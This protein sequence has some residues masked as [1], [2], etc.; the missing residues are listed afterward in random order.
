MKHSKLLII[1]ISLC[2]FM[3]LFA[4]P[5]ATQQMQGITV[6]GVGGVVSCSSFCDEY[7]DINFTPAQA[8]NGNPDRPWMAESDFN[9]QTGEWIQFTFTRPVGLVALRISPGF[10]HTEKRFYDYP[11][12]KKFHVTINKAAEGAGSET[13]HY[14]RRFDGAPYKDLILLYSTQPLVK[15]IRLHI[16]DVFP[17]KLK[18]YALIGNIEPIFMM[19]GQLQCSSTAVSDVLAFLH[20]SGNPESSF[21]FVPSGRPITIHKI[22]RNA[23]PLDPRGTIDKSDQFT[24]EQ[25][26]QQWDV[27]ADLSRRIFSDYQFKTY[28]A[29][30]YF[31][32]LEGGKKVFFDMFGPEHSDEMN[33]FQMAL[34][35]QQA[36]EE[37]KTVDPET[38]EEKVTTVTIM[39]SVVDKIMM[40]S[41]IYTP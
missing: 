36:T 16:D 12:L 21:A 1:C 13:R 17:G 4:L 7:D 18:N 22:F 6:N 33:S 24:R 15:S 31:W 38:K 26:R 30:N 19:D 35:R 27:W 9:P 29:V 32:T 39:K 20:A 28:E 34:S 10:G 3:L 25:I 37:V 41:D 2:C 23:N 14:Y 8:F 11:R 5:A 40:I